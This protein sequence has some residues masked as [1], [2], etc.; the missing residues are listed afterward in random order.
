MANSPMPP[1]LPHHVSTAHH[2]APPESG[3]GRDS[4]ASPFGIRVAVGESGPVL[5]LSGEADIT[6]L[7]QLEDALSAQLAAGAGILTVDLSGL[8]FADSATIGALIRAARTLKSQGGRLD[9]ARP[10]PAL[11]R[12]LALLGVDKVV[13]IRDDVPGHAPAPGCHQQ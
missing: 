5:M 3:G 1:H 13:P 8:G 9:L 12:M 6:T 7:A 11:A 4:A 10:Q 2:L